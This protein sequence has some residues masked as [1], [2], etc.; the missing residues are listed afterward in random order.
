ML[1]FLLLSEALFG[2]LPAAV[3]DTLLPL[4]GRVTNAL[5]GLGRLTMPLS[6][7]SSNVG[8]FMVLPA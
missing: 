8:P 6:V 1:S 5:W 7:L 4:I 2:R 3:L